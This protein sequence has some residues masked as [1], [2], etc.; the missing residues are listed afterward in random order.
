MGKTEVIVDTC[1]LQ[2]L[3]SEGKSIDNVKKVLAELEY[4]PVVHPYIYEHELSLYSYYKTLVNEGYMRVIKYG[5]FQKDAFDKQ[6]YEAYYDV[7]YEDMRLALEAIGGPKQINK[8]CL[9]NGQTI[10]DTHNQG[11][12]MGDVHMI[13]MAAY[14]KMPILLT[15]DS[16][17]EL[18][19]DIAKRKMQLGQYSLQILNGVQLIEEIAKK[20]DSSID[21]KELETILKAMG[22]RGHVSEMKT[23]WNKNHAE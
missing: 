23:I 10:Y 22:E 15:E 18:L 2:K 5:E 1:F 21:K 13:L 11:S 12:S 16:D 7:L 9:R 6:T 8:L 17:I 4:I 19:K 14:L 20:E 3:S